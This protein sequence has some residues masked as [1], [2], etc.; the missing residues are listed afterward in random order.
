MRRIAGPAW[1]LCGI[2]IKDQPLS[3]IILASAHSSCEPPGFPPVSAAVAIGRMPGR[4][5][6]CSTAR[7]LQMSV[8]ET[9]GFAEAGPPAHLTSWC[10]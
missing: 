3:R 7:Q 2:G 6:R 9:E 8:L 10:G 5:R 4:V 1:H